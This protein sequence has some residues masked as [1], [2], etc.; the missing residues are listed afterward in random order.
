[1]PQLFKIGIVKETGSQ[2]EDSKSLNFGREIPVLSGESTQ[3]GKTQAK[4]TEL[5]DPPL[6]QSTV[7]TIVKNKKQI[8]TAYKGGVYKDK[9]N[10][11][12]QSTYP[13]LDK[14]LSEWFTK[15]S[16]ITVAVNGPLLAE[17]AWYFTEQLGYAN[18]KASS[19]LLDRFKEHKA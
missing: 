8:I 15:L 11:L 16:S 19:R 17:K 2:E 1:M 14:A 10:T 5:F 6:P 18:F 4:V 3:Q 9:Q 12:K 7:V 13:D